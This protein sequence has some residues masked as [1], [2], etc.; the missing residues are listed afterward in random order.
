MR[1]IIQ[2]LCGFAVLAA[3]FY[4]WLWTLSFVNRINIYHNREAYKSETFL[5]SGAEYSRGDEGGDA[6]WLTGT[7]AARDE[8]FVPRLRGG[9]IPRSAKDLIE[10]Y[11]KDTKIAVLYNPD[12][13][14][15]L[16]QG[17]SLRVLSA[18]PDFW[19]EE[20]RLRYRLGVRVLLPVPLALAVYLVVRYVNRRHA[21]LHLQ[22]NAA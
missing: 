9:S 21:R 4:S 14:E 12:A 22:P 15:T 8:R 20:A 13:T 6:W 7:V 5:F 11:P 18:T 19:Q 2:S 17:E 10:R 1:K 3:I 16:V